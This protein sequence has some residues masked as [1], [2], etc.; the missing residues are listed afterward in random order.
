M[1]VIVSVVY[2]VINGVLQK[3]VVFVVRYELADVIKI[4]MIELVTQYAEVVVHRSGKLDLVPC[5]AAEFSHLTSNSWL[6]LSPM[7]FLNLLMHALMIGS[8]CGEYWR[9]TLH[10]SLKV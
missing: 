4:P 6:G 5:R 3:T 10:L 1:A 8:F 7:S 9:L 2:E